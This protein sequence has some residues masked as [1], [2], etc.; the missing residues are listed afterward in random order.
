VDS[1]AFKAAI[2]SKDRRTQLEAMRDHLA[3]ELASP[4]AGMAIAP[5]AKQLDEVLEKLAALPD[6]T[7]ADVVVDIRR[8]LA[9]LPAAAG[10]QSPAV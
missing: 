9:G 8:R 1:A 3:D 2:A 6:E 7:K 4:R 10:P 5:I